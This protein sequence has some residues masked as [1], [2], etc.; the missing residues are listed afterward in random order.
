MDLE[1]TLGRGACSRVIKAVSSK[2]HTPYALKQFPVATEEHSLML[3]QELQTLARVDCQCLVK[4]E[5]AYFQQ[6]TV[7]LVLEYMDRGSLD[8]LLMSS[9]A[10]SERVVGAIAYQLLWGLAYLHYENRMHRDVKPAN[11]L[12]NSRGNV[13]LS[14]FGISSSCKPTEMHT[15]VVGTT[16][17]MAPERLRALPYGTPSD[18]WSAGLVLCQCTSGIEPFHE[19]GSMV[20]KKTRL[21]KAAQHGLCQVSHVRLFHSGRTCGYSGR[22]G[23]LW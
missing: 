14:D 6:N 19:I 11:I 8:H 7:T 4:L 17:Y 16:R 20:R 13:K 5:G 9:H 22:N 2:T 10:L 23:R 1:G 3:S 15:T 21:V 12:L 18:V